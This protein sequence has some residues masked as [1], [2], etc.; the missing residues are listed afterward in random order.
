[1]NPRLTFT[2]PEQNVLLPFTCFSVKCLPRAWN[3]E[4]QPVT[5]SA[6]ALL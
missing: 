2:K 3:G 1:M 5:G 4:R 6:G